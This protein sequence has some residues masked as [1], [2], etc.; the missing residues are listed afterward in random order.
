MTTD[1]RTEN[2]ETEGAEMAKIETYFDCD[3]KKAVQ[4]Q[5]LNGNV[6]SLDNNG[7]RI[8][9]R[10]F[11]NG[12]K[13]TV[14]GTV[15]GRA[16]LADNST[17]NLNGGLTTVNG[18]S[19]AY[20][21][22]L[23]GALLIPGTIKITIQ[24]TASGVITTLAAIL[25]TVYQTKTDNVITPSAQVIADWNATISSAIQ[26]QNATISS[27]IQTQ[28]AAIA[29][30]TAARQA[31]DSDLKSFLSD[32]QGHIILSNDLK[33]ILDN[34]AEVTYSKNRYD[35][36]KKQDNMYLYSATGKA[37]EDTGFSVTG[38]I[39][40]TPGKYVTISRAV[41]SNRTAYAVP[42]YA[43]YNARSEN[44][45][46]SGSGGTYSSAI[47]VPSGAAYVR[48]CFHTNSDD[49]QIELTNDGVF[50]GYEAYSS[51]VCGLREDV[52]VPINQV[53]GDIAGAIETV[54]VKG[55]N[56]IP[57]SDNGTGA[58]ISSSGKATYYDYNTYHYAIIPVKKNTKYFVNRTPRWALLTD[59]DGNVI[60][61]SI[62][63]TG[64]ECYVETG[65]AT[66]LYFSIDNGSWY[67]GVIISEGLTGT[68]KN[69]QK[70]EF[71][72]GLNQHN[73]DSW[74]A[75]ALPKK[76]IR[77]TK[78]ITEKFYY[79]NMLSLPEKNIVGL[80]VNTYASAEDDGVS[81]NPQGTS[82]FNNYLFT[83]YDDNLSIIENNE[84][85]QVGYCASDNVQDCSVLLLGDST[86]EQ[87]VMGQKLIDAF[88]A[89]DK[90]VTLL[91]TNGTGDNKNEGR[92]GWS[93][94]DY[95][96]QSERGRTQN[97]FYNSSIEQFD[98]SKYMTDQSYSGVDFVVVQ[99]GI[100]DLYNVEMSDAKNAVNSLEENII[101]IITSIK[102]YNE[103]QK[104]IINLP[105]PCT[106]DSTKIPKVTQKLLRAKFVYYN[107]Q[108]IVLSTK[109]AGV[110]CSNCHLI[111]DPATDINDTIHPNANGYNKMALEILSQINVWQN[112][113]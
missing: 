72:K 95:C 9:V 108:M 26:T 97:P 19:V 67:F 101:E 25:S 39:P 68:S 73:F 90:T 100:N 57:V 24:L 1:K 52:E 50:T 29:A 86:V 48:V 28:N 111:L 16:I 43:F 89:R 7:N 40:V 8:G 46:I 109:F 96:G 99:L 63:M 110:R 104:I 11:D 2:D 80:T 21:D 14:T 41:Y 59:D 85:A 15:T 34:I 3:L 98:F 55:T 88:T 70:P 102:A 62:L 74:Y 92:S 18:Q 58:Y 61:S 103:N 66:K 31:A 94:A 51:P 91:G 69:E 78:G 81:I 64:A 84:Q 6:F 82:A 54:S 106:S 105:T 65:N 12:V 53:T 10:I 71:I 23:Q 83:V 20:V 5:P 27:A 79:A 13:T 77:F 75:L 42:S 76:N 32:D 112:E 45:F 113:S 93:A 47:L 35:P 4:V 22:V 17:V 107:S 36:S 49:L 33:T 87:G 37:A 60:S 30:E 38:F 56:L 44:D